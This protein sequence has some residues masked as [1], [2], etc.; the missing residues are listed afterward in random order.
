MMSQLRFILDGSEVKRYHT[1]TTIQQ[2]TV[3]HHSHGVAMLCCLLIEP[4]PRLL[5]AALTHDLA[6]HQ[7]G[8]LPSPAKRRYGIGDQVNALEQELLEEAGLFTDE[9]L[10]PAEARTLKLADIFQGMCF[11]VREMR[12]GNVRMNDI[13]QRY[14]SYAES[15]NPVGVER[16]IFNSI[17][18]L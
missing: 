16:D 11:C 13:F 14:I 15:M 1:V 9:E 2:E 12:L 6:E 18:G 10:T 17:K 7:L 8:D 3:G 4:T 5:F